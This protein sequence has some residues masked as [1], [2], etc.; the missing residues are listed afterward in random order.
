MYGT[1][2]LPAVACQYSASETRRYRDC[3]CT[4]FNLVYAPI[5]GDGDCFFASVAMLLALVPNAFGITH[6]ITASRM[7]A[8]VVEWLRN[9]ESSG[10][11]I[12]QQC[13]LHMTQ[14]LGLPIP[15][16]VGRK[17]VQTKPVDVDGY[18]QL[19]SQD[20]VWVQGMTP[21]YTT[22]IHH[23]APPSTIHH[24]TP[25]ITKTLTQTTIAPLIHHLNAIDHHTPPFTIHHLTPPI[26]TTLIQTTVTPLLHHLTAI[27]HHTPPSTIH[28]L[29]TGPHHTPPQH[30]AHNNYRRFP[31]AIRGRHYI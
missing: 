14:E 21:P 16:L 11:A 13:C 1:E 12:S 15:R 31:L 7:R 6:I 17:W 5:D 30:H 22:T 27:H 26:K 3:I 24:L 10:D 28:H 4:L 19:S 18:L 29:N 23:H 20:G 8:L 25:P 9:C 2:N